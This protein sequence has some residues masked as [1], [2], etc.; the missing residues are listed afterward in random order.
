M[1]VNKV[2]NEMI[3]YI[4]KNLEEN[5]DYKDLAKIMCVNENTMQKL[6]SFL[7]DCSLAD[8][9]RKRR[10]TKAGADLLSRKVYSHGDWSQV[11]VQ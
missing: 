1:K 5:I 8:Y 9:I 4:E 10:L 2:L 3:D 6:F 7:C 11:Y